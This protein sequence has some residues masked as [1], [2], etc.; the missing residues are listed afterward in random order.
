TKQF[1]KATDKTPY[2]GL[3]FYRLLQTDF[4]G[5]TEI[6]GIEEFV[7]NSHEEFDVM[8]YPNPVIP[9]SKIII[10]TSFEFQEDIN[11][12]ISSFDGTDVYTDITQI[13]YNNTSVIILEP[14]Q[15]LSKGL[16]LI[17][18]EVENKLVSKK[19]LVN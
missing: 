5:K 3:S 9:N 10:K 13:N 8:I 1:Y 15:P 16:Y 4:D 17:T 12:L 6:V 18:F 11:L 19:L 7:N 14:Q 2:Q